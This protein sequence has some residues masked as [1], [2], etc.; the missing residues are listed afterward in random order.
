MGTA[1]AGFQIQQ[2]AITIQSEVEKA[3]EVF[4]RR[5]I[6]LTGASRTDAGVHAF[7]NYFHFDDAGEINPSSVYNLNALLPA[8][9]SVKR[10]I[11]VNPFPI[12]A[13]MP[14]A[15]NTSISYIKTKTHSL[16][17]GLISILIRSTL[18]Y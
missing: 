10:I 6:E 12:P 3:L 4:F 14:A 13:L 9:I 18:I 2:N 16:M 8:D 5:K 1:Y 11:R 15:A 7:Q 17:I